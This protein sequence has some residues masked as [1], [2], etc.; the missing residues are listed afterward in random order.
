MGCYVHARVC[1]VFS[2]IA[3]R[4]APAISRDRYRC[5][6]VDYSL[7][8]LYDVVVEEVI[9]S[10]QDQATLD[11]IKC[12]LGHKLKVEKLHKFFYLL[13]GFATQNSRCCK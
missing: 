7:F 4:I 8:L 6:S 10:W 9:D 1:A 13:I 3:R 12:L 11:A 5:G 2:R